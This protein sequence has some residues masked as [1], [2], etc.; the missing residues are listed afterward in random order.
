MTDPDTSLG[1]RPRAGGPEVTS[2]RVGAFEVPL[3]SP[4]SDG[5]LSW[6]STTLVVV[7]VRAGDEV[8]TGY[9]Y[10]PRAA[11][12]VVED[13]LAGVVT[14]R[15]AFAV[16][17]AWGAMAHAV[18]NQGRRGPVSA[19]ISA[20]DVALWDLKARL[21]GL[22]LV[23]LLGGYHDH[24]PAYGS[25]GFTRCSPPCGTPATSST[26]PTTCGSRRSPS[27]GCWSPTTARCD[28]TAAAPATG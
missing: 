4:E 11:A 14:G 25:G 15:D 8:G 1:A 12:L 3:D 27:T 7:T 22:S 18:R 21:L 5:T 2:V 17:A 19:A 23:D 24:V 28:P 26:S 13:T 10:A 20:V 6:D 16:G 9:T